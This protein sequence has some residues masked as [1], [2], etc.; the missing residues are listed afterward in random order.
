MRTR[1]T[2]AT[3]MLGLALAGALAGALVPTIG[4]SPKRHVP[5]SDP[6]AALP[7]AFE[8]SATGY[9]S[10]GPGYSVVLTPTETV[11]R[12]RPGRELRMRLVG[13]NPDPAL[14]GRSSLPGTANYLVGQDP[15]A[16]RCGGCSFA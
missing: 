8:P 7:L 16:W 15:G 4:S 12:L 13:A 14:A 1:A 9:V 10:R 5:G 11:M 2:L 3:A 6:L